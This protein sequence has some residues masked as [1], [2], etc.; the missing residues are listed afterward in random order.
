VWPTDAAADDAADEPDLDVAGTP[1]TDPGEIVVR[2]DNLFA[3]YWPDG[4]GG[5]DPDGWW[6]TGDIAYA[7]GDGDL[8]LVDRIGELIIVNGFNVYPREVEQA[9][10][11]HPGVVEAAAVGVPDPDAGQAVRAY[12]VAVGAPSVE[13]LAAHCARRLA[14]FKCPRVIEL[15]DELPRSAIGKVRKT[16]L[17]RVDSGD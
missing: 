9:L 5:P 2:G 11:A 16:E 13:E 12:V 3:G 15:V 6:G 17:R 14:R 7:D 10:A 8:F 4:R 1:G